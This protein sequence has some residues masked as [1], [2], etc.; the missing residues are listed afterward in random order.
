MAG[1]V[2]RVTDMT[3]FSVKNRDIIVEVIDL[4]EK[5]AAIAELEQ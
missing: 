3:N 4:T 2:I 5:L 1:T